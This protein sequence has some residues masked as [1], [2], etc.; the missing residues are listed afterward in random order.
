MEVN[1][2]MAHSS[3]SSTSCA[4]VL[5]LATHLSVTLYIQIIQH[6]LYLCLRDMGQA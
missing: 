4:P 5:L 1:L 2:K 6:D 3:L